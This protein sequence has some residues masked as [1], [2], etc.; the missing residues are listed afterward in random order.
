[1]PPAGTK[2]WALAAVLQSNS[3]QSDGFQATQKSPED[4]TPV[5]QKTVQ[6]G[7]TADQ[8]A[9]GVERVT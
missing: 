5:P 4:H 1:M 9:V 7:T 2:C 3:W 8:M 6:T